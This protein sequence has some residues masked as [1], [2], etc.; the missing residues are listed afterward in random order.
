MIMAELPSMI[1]YP[2]KLKIM[3]L[4]SKYFKYLTLFRLETTLKIIQTMQTQF[5]G[6]STSHLIRVNNVYLQ[7]SVKGKTFT[8]DTLN[9]NWTQMIWMDKSI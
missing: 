6:R 2:F 4:L 7:N 8:R 1:L 5:E 3:V 9:Y